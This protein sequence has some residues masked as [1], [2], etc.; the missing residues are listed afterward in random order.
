MSKKSLFF[1]VSNVKNGFL[2]RKSDEKPK[3]LQKHVL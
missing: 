1:V 3:K 2:L